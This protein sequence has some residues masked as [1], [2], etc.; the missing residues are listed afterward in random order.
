[1]L[2]FP[3]ID[4]RRTPV[5]LL[6]VAV[7]VA[8]TLIREIDDNARKTYFIKLV[9]WSEIWAGEFWRPLTTTLLHGDLLH[10]FFNLYC[11]LLFGIPLETWIGSWRIAG[12]MALLGYV[13][14]L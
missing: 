8:L 6:L 13:S 9:I 2:Y 12:L 5:T 11:I 14:S 4:F 10:A 7:T 1:M 3:P